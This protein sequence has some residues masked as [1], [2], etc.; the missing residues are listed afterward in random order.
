MT[1]NLGCIHTGVFSGVID[2]E[3]ATELSRSLSVF[4]VPLHSASPIPEADEAST[5]DDSS[6]HSTQQQ[7][8]LTPLM[9]PVCDAEG[10]EH[11]QLMR[12]DSSVAV[13]RQ[14]TGHD[15]S[16]LSIPSTASVSGDSID[17]EAQLND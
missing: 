3:E 1:S 16:A 11:G 13:M 8:L 6:S 10:T 4:K 9:T 14:S 12:R 15:D 5:E 2:P 7:P 17:D